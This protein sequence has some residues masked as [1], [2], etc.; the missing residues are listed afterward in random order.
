MT[1]PPTTTLWRPVGPVELELIR[2]SGMK[3]FPPRLPD[4][5]IFYPVLSEDYAVQI[6][7]DWNAPASGSGFVTRFEVRADFLSRYEV[8]HAGSRAHLEYWIP[9]DELQA[10]NDA[11]V[12]EI[13]VT[14]TF[15]DAAT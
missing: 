6:A 12:G 5:P 2:T 1:K 7:R 9:A 13:V 11:I 10:F 15:G 14:A 8:Q 4:Q 3:A